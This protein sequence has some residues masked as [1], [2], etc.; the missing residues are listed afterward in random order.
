MLLA[1]QTNN[2]T[3]PKKCLLNIMTLRIRLKDCKAARN[4]ETPSC[5][6]TFDAQDVQGWH[7]CRP[8]PHAA[9]GGRG[10]SVA[11][12]HTECRLVRKKVMLEGPVKMDAV[13]SPLLYFQ[14]YGFELDTIQNTPKTMFSLAHVVK[15]E[16]QWQELA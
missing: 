13:S 11:P 9:Q 3:N 6:G 2:E 4:F 1:K 7:P 5:S 10:R 12:A 16:S 8:E 15:Q 14:E